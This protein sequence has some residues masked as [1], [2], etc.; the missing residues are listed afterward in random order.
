MSEKVFAHCCISDLRLP[1]VRDQGGQSAH[2][3]LSRFSPDHKWDRVQPS[4]G[5]PLHIHGK[6][7]LGFFPLP[8]SEAKRLQKYLAFETRFSALDPCAGDG[9]AYAAL[10]ENAPGN[11]Y[12]VEIDA[13]RAAQAKALG[14]DVLHANALDVRC[15]VESVSLLYLNPPYDWE[16]GQSGNQRLELVFLEHTFRWLRCDGVLIFVIPQARLKPCARILADHFKNI[17]IYRL[18]APECVQYKQIAVLASRRKRS[19]RSRDS[20]LVEAQQYLER[21]SLQQDL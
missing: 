6:A 9:I 5:L 12:A 4:E 8:V 16:A 3:I 21:M 17:R 15:P 20:V 1:F 14:L 2:S 18:T 10:L 13:Y 19:E 7:K 11:R